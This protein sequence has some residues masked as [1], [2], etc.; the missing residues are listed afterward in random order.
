M[1]NT[2]TPQMIAAI[3]FVFFL[4]LKSNNMN[5]YLPK[6]LFLCIILRLS[7]VVLF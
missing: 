5:F 2:S 4:L 1:A 7:F 6:G 3:L